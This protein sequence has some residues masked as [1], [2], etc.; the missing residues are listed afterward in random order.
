MATRNERRRRAK[1]KQ[2]AF[3]AAAK[4]HQVAEIVR[5]NM[6]KPIERNYYAGTISSVYTGG[7][8]ARANGGAS[9]T[10]SFNGRI[11]RGKLVRS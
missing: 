2:K 11:V 8:A 5:A 4:A 7:F 9:P 1:A 10:R 3:L 6:A